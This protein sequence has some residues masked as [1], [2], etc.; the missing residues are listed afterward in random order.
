MVV[1]NLT[2]QND[3]IRIDRSSPWPDP[4]ATDLDRARE[5]ELENALLRAR[6]AELRTRLDDL[7]VERNELAQLLDGDD[8][9]S[10]RAFEAFLSVP[11]PQLDKVRRFLL[12]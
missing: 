11:D 9:A 4:P 3:G 1:R 10:A 7:A 5:L 12:D 8:D 2:T 6:V